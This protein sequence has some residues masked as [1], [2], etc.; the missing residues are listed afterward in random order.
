MRRYE[1]VFILDPGLDDAACDKEIIKVEELLEKHKGKLLK[2]DRWGLRRLSYRIK[3]KTEGYYVLIQFEATS[4]L[5][6]ELERHFKLNEF[7]LRSL[8][9]QKENEKSAEKD[10]KSASAEENKDMVEA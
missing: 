1:T 4:D 10:M 5:V 2:T 9:V 7:C 8:I 3:K 6:R